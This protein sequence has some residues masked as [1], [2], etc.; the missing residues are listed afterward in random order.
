MPWLK[1][2]VSNQK[3]VAYGSAVVALLIALYQ[4]HDHVYDSGYRAAEVDL[5]S[6][7]NKALSEQREKYQADL[8]NRVA[9]LQADHNDEV[10]RVR[11]ERETITKVEKV[12]EYVDKEILVEAQCDD[13]AVSVVRMLK[14]AT[15]IT[16]RRTADNP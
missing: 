14:Q 12:I 3:Y 15:D 7:H 10:E 11:S 16:R 9:Q 5:V 6:K 2:L 4:L 13:L 1:W 8:D